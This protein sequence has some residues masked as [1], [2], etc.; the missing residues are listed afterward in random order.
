[1]GKARRI[2]LST[3]SFEKAGDATNFFREM[4]NKYQIGERVNAEDSVHLAALLTRHDEYADKVGKGIVAFEVNVPPSDVPQFSQRCFWIVRA[5][6]TKI[7]FS[8]V[9]CL[10]AR[11]GD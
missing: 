11:P 3:C 5:D 9:H 7:D 4:L 10:K 6:D 8:F 2:L 1:M